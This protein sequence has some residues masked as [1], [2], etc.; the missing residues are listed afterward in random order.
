[1]KEKKNTFT[2]PPLTLKDGEISELIK[3]Y[4]KYL[5]KISK[6]LSEKKIKIPWDSWD[7]VFIDQLGF[8]S[9]TY[10]CLKKA[11]IHTVGDIFDDISLNYPK[12]RYFGTEELGEIALKLMELVDVVVARYL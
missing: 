9:R 3:K 11:N 2:S 6:E 5:E 10:N 7:S 1:M 4:K 12:I 8:A